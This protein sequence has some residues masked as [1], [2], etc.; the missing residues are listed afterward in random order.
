[1][2]SRGQGVPRRDHK[3]KTV[4]QLLEAEKASDLVSGFYNTI[5]QTQ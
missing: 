2:T 1:M 3:P 4:E 5:P